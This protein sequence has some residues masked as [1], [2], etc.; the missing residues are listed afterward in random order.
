MR[1]VKEDR[2][3]T[4]IHRIALALERMAKSLELELH[5]V[6]MELALERMSKSLELELCTLE[7]DGK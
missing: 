1:N 5:T 6:N 4:D 7:D 3:Y 2:F